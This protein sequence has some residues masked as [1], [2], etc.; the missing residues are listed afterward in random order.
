MLKLK[1]IKKKEKVNKMKIETL[2]TIS[3]EFEQNKE[4]EQGKPMFTIS[5]DMVVVETTDLFSNP[6]SQDYNALTMFLKNHLETLKEYHDSNE[7]YG[8]A[9][10]ECGYNGTEQNIFIKDWMDANVRVF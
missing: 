1:H 6:T 3:E 2:E 7:N 9:F 10:Y 8:I 4:I 5:K